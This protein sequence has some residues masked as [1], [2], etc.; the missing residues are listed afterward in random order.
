MC[1]NMEGAVS[2]KA[3]VCL[4]LDAVNPSLL[5]RRGYT[6]SPD[7]I[8]VLGE[9]EELSEWVLQFAIGLQRVGQARCQEEHTACRCLHGW[10][11]GYNGQSVLR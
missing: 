2:A 3:S 6:A 7:R 9:D 1:L 8:L 5:N 11:L 4:T 10:L